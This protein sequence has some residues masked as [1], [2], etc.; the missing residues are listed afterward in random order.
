MA[1][2]PFQVGFDGVFLLEAAASVQML[3]RLLVAFS[4]EARFISG[5]QLF[6][7]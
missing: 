5:K 3:S 7:L 6:W 4:S 2:D 1:T